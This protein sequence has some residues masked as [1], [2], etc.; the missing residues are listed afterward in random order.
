MAD[1]NTTATATP[2]RITT[3]I[4]APGTASTAGPAKPAST[5]S[6]TTTRAA[7]ASHTGSSSIITG[8]GHAIASPVSSADS[9]GGSSGALLGGIAAGVVGLIAIVGL[10]FYKRRRRSATD[11]SGKNKMGGKD[12][13][14]SNASLSTHGAISGPLSLAPDSGIA[15]TPSHR[16][17]AQ[18]REQQQFPPGMRDELFAQPGATLNTT[19]S[20][21]KDGGSTPEGPIGAQRPTTQSKDL[22]HGN[23]TPAP[24]Y[25]LGKED[26]DPRRDLRGLDTP[27]TYI[28]KSQGASDS[29][30]QSSS[31]D[32]PRSSCSS[33][34]E[35]VYM[36]LEQAQQAH[37]NKMM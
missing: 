14:M 19:L 33:D 12:Q 30:Q 32:T 4:R 1:R 13:P 20:N 31:K 16:P 29:M 27:E 2:R 21:K 25:Y 3:T 36:T 5:H 6:T 7:R 15:A 35:S 9:T 28:K 34:N 18:F 11:A 10:L 8:T 22:A 26:I 37:N 23:L 24:E 17:E